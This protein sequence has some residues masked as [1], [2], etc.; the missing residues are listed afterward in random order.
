MD[1]EPRVLLLI[2]RLNAGGAARVT[3]RV[4]RGLAER[5]YEVHMAAVTGQVSNDL[6]AAGITMHWLDARRVRYGAWRLIRLVRRLRP[7]VILSNMAHLNLLVLALRPAF[8]LGTRILVRND[9]GV[10]PELLSG[11]RR[12]AFRLLHATA[13]AVICQSDGM[14]E[15]LAAQLG[16]RERLRVLPNPVAIRRD[17]AAERGEQRWRGS[18]PNLLAVGRL[19]QRKGFDLLLEAFAAI[20]MR[21]PGAQLAIVGEG[22]ERQRM[23]ALAAE[24]GLA[25]RV[26]FTGEMDDPESWF[27]GATMFVVAS[28]EDAL[29]NALLEAAAAGLPIVATPA[30]GGVPALLAGQRGAW[31]AKEVSASALAACLAEALASLAPGQRFDHAWMEP[32]A[33]DNAIAGYDDLIRS[34]ARTAP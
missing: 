19:E 26:Q 14:K 32:F 1:E 8:P 22:P 3:T 7:Q 25:G 9:G 18:G 6:G 23:G 12:W 33:W 29:P 15:E 31:I 21:F 28:R 27:P 10:H 34:V 24:L 5:G 11:L 16:N 4:A 20:S 30:R 13:D 17:G 2:P